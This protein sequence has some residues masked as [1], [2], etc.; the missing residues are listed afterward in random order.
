M[1]TKTIYQAFQESKGIFKSFFDNI[2]PTGF[3]ELDEKM[4]LFLGTFNLLVGQPGTGK[5]S[6][7]LNMLKYASEYEIPTLLFNADMSQE[8]L[9]QKLGPVLFGEKNSLSGKEFMKCFTRNDTNVISVI[10]DKF[11]SLEDRVLMSSERELKVAD[12]AKEIDEREKIS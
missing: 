9:I 4:P 3:K 12:I 2:V 1:N 6:L 8:M 11:K 7:V 10:E 5:T